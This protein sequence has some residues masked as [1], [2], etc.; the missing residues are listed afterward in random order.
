MH[1]TGRA[2]ALA[3]FGA[4]ALAVVAAAAAG[5]PMKP[6]PAVVAPGASAPL[7]YTIV[8]SDP[9]STPAGA[10][11]GGGAFC[12][13]GLVALGGGV[14]VQSAS[15]LTGVNGSFPAAAGAGWIAQVN[16]GSTTDTSFRVSV[17][18][19]RMPRLYTIV[20]SNPVPNPAETQS[21]AFA[22]CP[23]HTKP[24]SGG[25]FSDSG[26]PSTNIATTLVTKHGWVVSESNASSSNADI[27][28][29]AVCGKVRGYATFAGQTVLNP[30]QRQSS[31]FAACPP[32]SVV[33]GGGTHSSAVG[34]ESSVNTSIVGASEWDSAENNN[35]PSGI[36][37][38]HTEVECAGVVR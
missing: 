31:S 7:G 28:A 23:A 29:F 5:T 17:I 34:I 36:L 32:G 24:F 38:T 25:V 1:Q 15:T 2:A 30:A 16:N 19:A 6:A 37:Q 26:L 11:T 8:T 9:V 27:T 18:C 13:T 10:Q 33:I 3:A 20:E 12:P 4:C 35:A 14:V 21:A 22:D